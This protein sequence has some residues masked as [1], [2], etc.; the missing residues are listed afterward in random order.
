M[1]NQPLKRKVRLPTI[2]PQWTCPLSGPQ[3]QV[4]FFN[5]KYKL[6]SNVAYYCLF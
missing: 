2:D 5:L 6:V 1:G 3:Y 4:V